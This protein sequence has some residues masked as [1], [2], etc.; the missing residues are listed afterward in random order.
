METR[1]LKQ[2]RGKLYPHKQS[3]QVGVLNGDNR[4][5]KVHLVLSI[6]TIVNQYSSC[7]NCLSKCHR[8]Y[9]Q[10]NGCSLQIADTR[11]HIKNKKTM[12]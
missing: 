2:E 5:P 8:K 3:H 4:Q 7:K 12:S 11:L 10:A 9:Q 1:D 6:V